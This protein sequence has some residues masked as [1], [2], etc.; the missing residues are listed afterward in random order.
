VAL[1]LADD[2]EPLLL[3]IA[4][5][6]DMAALD[7]AARLLRVA[8]VTGRSLAELATEHGDARLRRLYFG[9]RLPAFI[10]EGAPARV[11]RRLPPPLRRIFAGPPRGASG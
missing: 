10:Y 4:P 2:E 6:R 7:A 3:P 1:R 9:K 11:A 5:T 8:A